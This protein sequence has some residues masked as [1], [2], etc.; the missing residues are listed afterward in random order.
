MQV[1][2]GAERVFRDVLDG[3]VVQFEDLQAV[4]VAEDALLQARNA[5]EAHIQHNQPHQSRESGAVD[6]F[7]GQLVVR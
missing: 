1:V 7:G 6:P 4:Q 5:I 3:I 2:Q